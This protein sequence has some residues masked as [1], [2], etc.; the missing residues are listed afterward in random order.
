MQGAL[1]KRAVARAPLPPERLT[2]VLEP[3]GVEDVPYHGPPCG[4]ALSQNSLGVE[5]VSFL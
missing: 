1:A 3:E 4:L 2:T 5:L